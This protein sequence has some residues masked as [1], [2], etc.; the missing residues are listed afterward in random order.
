[1]DDLENF[2]E[3]FTGKTKP[4]TY[5]ITFVLSPLI[6]A[7][8]IFGDGLEWLADDIGSPMILDDMLDKTDMGKL[9]SEVGIYS[10]KLTIQ[11][12]RTNHPE[13]PEEWDT[14]FGLDA[15]RKIL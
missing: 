13:D 15:I 2:M 9:P 6:D 11:S 8:I 7:T 10:A 12:F 3:R 4:A 1:M 5:D 14:N